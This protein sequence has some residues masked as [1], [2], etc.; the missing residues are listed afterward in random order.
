MKNYGKIGL[1]ILVAALAGC[2]SSGSG[3]PEKIVLKGAPTKGLAYTHERTEKVDGWLT[4]R[5]DGAESKQPLIK[6]E[7]RVWEDE[8][9]EVDGPRVVQVRRKT[10]EWTLKR[11][12]AGETAM[13]TVPRQLVGKTIVLRRTDLG[14]EYENAA[15]L[16][17][18]ELSANVLGTL[19]ALVSPPAEAVGVGS[20]WPIDGDRL[21]D[22]FG[23]E[24]GSRALKVRSASGTGRLE[25][26]DAD[27]IAVITVKLTI[28]GSMRA[29]L[30]VDVTMDM[31]AKFRVDLNAGRPLSF[32]AHAEGKI[33]GEV[34]RQGKSAIYDGAFTFDTTG[35]NKYR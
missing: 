24:E 31:T 19:E 34:D 10:L 9:L 6:D 13:Q 4:V 35:S 14:T 28:G 18:E 5:A 2:A 29:L 11:Q 30:D 27:R 23:G 3:S 7:R 33:A 12:R 20:E 1:S 21:V 15:G 25:S 8:I 32:Q 16:P 17:A 26:I 22:L